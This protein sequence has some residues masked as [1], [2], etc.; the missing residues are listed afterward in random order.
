LDLSSP[1]QIKGEVRFWC[2]ASTYKIKGDACILMLKATTVFERIN[3]CLIDKL[4]IKY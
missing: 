4:K 3:N 2:L 1:F